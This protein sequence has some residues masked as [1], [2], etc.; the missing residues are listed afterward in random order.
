MGIPVDGVGNARYPAVPFSEALEERAGVCSISNG[1]FEIAVDGS[2]GQLERDRAGRG[3]GNGGAIL[4]MQLTILTSVLICISIELSKK[5]KRRY[6]F[7]FVLV[8]FDVGVSR[9]DLGG[10]DSVDDCL[11]YIPIRLEDNVG[12]GVPDQGLF[13][14]SVDESRVVCGEDALQRLIRLGPKLELAKK[15]GDTKHSLPFRAKRLR[16][17]TFDRPGAIG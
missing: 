12:Y 11:Y 6:G 14:D 3:E 4:S 9:G 1:T 13:F 15:T 2:S 17:V 10:P 16:V 7:I 8:S 5:R